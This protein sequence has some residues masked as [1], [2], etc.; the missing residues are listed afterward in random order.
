MNMTSPTA[1]RE[2][3][4]YEEKHSMISD[5]T[6]LFSLSAGDVRGFM[7]GYGPPL[8]D[9]EMRRLQACFAGMSTS[10]V[11]DY[12]QFVCDF[13]ASAIDRL[14]ADCRH[15]TDERCTETASH[16]TTEDLRDEALGLTIAWV[17]R[18][19]DD[20]GYA[21]TERGFGMLR[22][23][24]IETFDPGHLMDRMLERVRGEKGCAA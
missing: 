17:E 13:L 10:W 18:F 7:E 9:D 11:C 4:D 15:H 2:G 1:T 20:K 19:F 24:V 23:I 3:A 21:M 22:E 6:L 12:G 14:R 16:F 8:S 5:E